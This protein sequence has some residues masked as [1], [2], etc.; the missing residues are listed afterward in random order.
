MSE[1]Q[2]QDAEH[3]PADHHHDGLAPTG[4]ALLEHLAAAHGVDVPDRLSTGTLQGMH[5]R[6]HGEAHAADD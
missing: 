5:D 3:G 1:D 4:D 2:L 6:F